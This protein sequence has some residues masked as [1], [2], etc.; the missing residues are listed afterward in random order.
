MGIWIS[1]CLLVSKMLLRSVA[2]PE[3]GKGAAA[4]PHTPPTPEAAPKLNFY[5][6][7][8][9]KFVYLMQENSRASRAMLP[10]TQ[11][12]AALEACTHPPPTHPANTPLDPA[13]LIKIK[14]IILICMTL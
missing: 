1:F 8:S 11:V 9:N 12:G 6:N 4:N 3:G 7:F 14:V 10:T 2:D 5:F 13:L